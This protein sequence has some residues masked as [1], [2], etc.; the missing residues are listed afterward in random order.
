MEAITFLAEFGVV[1]SRVVE[2][3]GAGVVELAEVGVVELADVGV[4]D[5]V[6]VV[7]DCGVVDVT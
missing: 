7:V 4:V 1:V 6:Y 2:L 5:V 3:V